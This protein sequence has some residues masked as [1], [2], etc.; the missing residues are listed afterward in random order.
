[1]DS[2][3]TTVVYGADSFPYSFSKFNSAL[4]T[5]LLNP[6]SPPPP[7]SDKA[8]S[9]PALFEMIASEPDSIPR[10]QILDPN[11]DCQRFW[12]LGV[13]EVSSVTPIRASDVTRVLR[14]LKVSAA[15]GFD[16]GVLLCLEYLEAAPWAKDEEE[17]LMGTLPAA[18]SSALL[19]EYRRLVTDPTSPIQEFYPFGCIT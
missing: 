7:P 3:T 18:S 5:G 13:W 12:V 8:Q 14:I 10:S 1:M 6:M 9:S 15:T 4:T 16:A 19:E 2:S 11:S 17:N